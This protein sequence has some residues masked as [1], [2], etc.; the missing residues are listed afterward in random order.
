MRNNNEFYEID[1][2]F[3][4]GAP[5]TVTQS[6]LL[7]LT[8]LLHH[9]IDMLCL[10][11]II[12]VINLHCLSEQ[13]KKIPYINFVNISLLKQQIC[14][15]IIIVRFALGIS[16]QLKIFVLH[17]LERTIH[18]SYNYRFLNNYGKCI[19][20]LDFMINRKSVLKE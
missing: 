5:L 4:L 20:G 2:A 3:Y 13:L 7:I 10:S 16:N 12:T 8:L 9:N 15:N 17:V 1:E 6:M 18:I 19:E 11:D 14:R